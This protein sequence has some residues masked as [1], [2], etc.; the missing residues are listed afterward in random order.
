MQA[1]LGFVVVVGFMFLFIFERE[2]ER[3]EE[4][5]NKGSEAGS[6]P[7]ARSPMRG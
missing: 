7:T 1:D 5:G 3:G 2:H 6:V 4:R